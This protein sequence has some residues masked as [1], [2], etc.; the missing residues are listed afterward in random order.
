MIDT[1]WLNVGSLLFGLIAFGIPIVSILLDKEER[2]PKIAI[3]II[4]SFSACGISICMQI[5]YTDHLV[6]IEDWS[7]L[8]DTSSTVAYISLILLIVTI[9]FNIVFLLRNVCLHEGGKSHIKS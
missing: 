4:A 8:M 6:K 2:K 1:L 3:P 7:A 9:I 5:F